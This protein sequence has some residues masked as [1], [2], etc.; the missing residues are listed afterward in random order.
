MSHHGQPPSPFSV[1][2]DPDKFDK[3]R[4]AL[5]ATGRFPEGKLNKTDEGEL[6]L[7]VR[8]E[9]DKVFVEFGTSVAWIGFSPQQ[10]VDVAQM[11]I[12]HA[13]QATSKPITLD[14]GK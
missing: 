7:A 6:R 2:A 14:L 4:E 8:H 1:D 11:L 13:R 5:G 9:P 3:L 12:R 10:A